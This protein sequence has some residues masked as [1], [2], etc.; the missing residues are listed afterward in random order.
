M[1][2][3]QGIQEAQRDNLRMIANMRPSGAF[4]RMIQFATVEAHRYAV[5]ITHVDTGALKASHRMTVDGPIGRIFIDST[6]V[7]PRG[8]RPSIY[9]PIEH[10]RGGGHAFYYRT[11]QEAGSRIARAAATGFIRE[12][13]R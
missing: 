5:T 4:G 6:A 13:G 3:I 10:A 2:T 9:G 11:E 12:L 1:I 7:N 8:A